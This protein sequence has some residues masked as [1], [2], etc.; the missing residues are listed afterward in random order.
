[1]LREIFIA[2]KIT[3]VATTYVGLNCDPP[4]ENHILDDCLEIFES[5]EPCFVTLDCLE[6]CQG[7]CKINSNSL[8][9]M[10]C[11]TKYACMWKLP[12]V[13]NDPQTK[14]A[15]MTNES[16]KNQIWMNNSTQNDI[17]TKVSKVYSFELW[18]IAALAS[19]STIFVF[20]LSLAV[21]IVKCKKRR[22]FLSNDI[23]LSQ[24]SN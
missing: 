18:K 16:V 9:L 12:Q 19:C 23:E 13:V 15:I 4:S 24:L 14:E 11:S 22:A 3:L 21:C 10:P 1:M 2:F 5:F 8:L 20:A 17:K 6:L 7:R